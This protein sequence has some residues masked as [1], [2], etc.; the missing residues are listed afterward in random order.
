MNTD[1]QEY[2]DIIDEN[3]NVIGKLARDEVYANLHPHRIVHVMVFNDQGQILLQKRSKYKESK[4]LHWVTSVSGHVMSG[5]T[6]EHAALRETQE[7]IGIMPEIKFFS[8]NWY[9]SVHRNNIK[10][11]LSI[12]EAKH[13]GPFKINKKEV[14]E[15]KFF[16]LPDIYQMIKDG[17]LMH[18]ELLYILEKDFGIKF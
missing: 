12:F 18:P 14:E 9:T 5:E 16:S 4:P 6:V 3:D 15:V 17:E 2:L 8:K 7:E 11:L 13:N 10:K 1:K